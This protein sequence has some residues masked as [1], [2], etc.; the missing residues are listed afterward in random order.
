M[1]SFLARLCGHCV[2]FS[3]LLGYSG[4]QW[5]QTP[6]RGNGAQ[7]P[8]SSEASAPAASSAPGGHLANASPLT[9]A[10][11]QQ[12]V[13]RCLVRA[14][15]MSKFLGFGPNDGA[16]LLPAPGEADQRN[17][18]VAFELRK[19]D[20]LSYVSLNLT[21]GEPG[22]GCGASYDAVSYWTANC[23]VVARQVFGGFQADGAIRQEVS[24]LSAGP[25]SK[26]FLL[27]AGL[28]GCVSI[29]REI[30]QN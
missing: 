24:V 15:Q 4:L 14:E 27:P 18:A 5:A 12:G 19:P 29:K 22:S 28:A 26:V 7:N 17:V 2:V 20:L 21:P 10:L 13:R 3:M 16:L 8:K 30:L 9:Q 25:A 11:A 23:A 1:K 6:K